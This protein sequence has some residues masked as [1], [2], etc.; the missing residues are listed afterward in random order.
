VFCPAVIPRGRQVSEIL[1]LSIAVAIT[2]TAWCSQRSPAGR[3]SRSSSADQLTDIFEQLEKG[4]AKTSSKAACSRPA[5]RFSPPPPFLSKKP[6][7]RNRTSPF[8]VHGNK[9]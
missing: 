8:R 9:F 4:P 2:T 7:D 6:A 1:R 3:L 5:Y